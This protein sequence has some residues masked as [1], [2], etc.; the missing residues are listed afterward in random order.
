MDLVQ[1]LGTRVRQRREHLGWS[2]T[3]LA[4]QTG[5]PT[6]NLSRIEHGRQSIYIARLVDLAEALQ[7]STDYLLGRTDDPTPVPPNPPPKRPR[8]RKTTPVG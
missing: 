6:P 2:Q 5:I 4:E 1:I 7:V 8:S 3:A